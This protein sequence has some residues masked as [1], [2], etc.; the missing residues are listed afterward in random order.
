MESHSCAGLWH[1]L[2]SQYLHIGFVRI[3]LFLDTAG[4]RSEDGGVKDLFLSWGGGVRRLYAL[5]NAALT[6]IFCAAALGG[7]V[8]PVF[9]STTVRALNSGGFSFSRP[10]FW[11]LPW[12][13]RAVNFGSAESLGVAPDTRC[14]S[15]RCFGASQLASASRDFFAGP[16]ATW[17]GA[18]FLAEGPA[19]WGAWVATLLFALGVVAGLLTVVAAD[20]LGAGAGF[21]AC[22]L[23]EDVEDG[24]GEGAASGWDACLVLFR[25]AARAAFALSSSCRESPL[26]ELYSPSLLLPSSL[27]D[28][29]ETTLL[30]VFS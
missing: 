27:E 19:R 28:V 7:I 21:P 29:S 22:F 15:L 4:A 11:Y 8:L 1:P 24:F 23:M 5:G 18:L 13:D 16:A 2:V 6:G 9:R 12:I 30:R 26:L 20:C 25:F 3:L 14:R 17:L 10:Y